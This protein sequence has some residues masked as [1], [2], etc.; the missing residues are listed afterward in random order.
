LRE[1]IEGELIPALIEEGR[2]LAEGD[3]RGL[4]YA[5]LAEEIQRRAARAQHWTETYWEHFIPYAHGARLFGQVYNDAVRPQDPFEFIAL[6]QTGDMESVRRNAL[7][8]RIADVIR[9]DPAIAEA[10]ESGAGLP[11]HV[12]QMISELAHLVTPGESRAGADTAR[13]ARLALQASRVQGETTGPD[14]LAR[15]ALERRFLESVSEGQRA[16]ALELLDLARSSYRLRDDDNVYLGR[17]EAQVAAATEE[18]RRRLAGRVAYD[19]ETLAPADVVFALRDTAFVPIGNAAQAPAP[20]ATVR[21]RQLTGQPAGPGV[22]T[23]PARVIHDGEDLFRVEAGDVLVCDAIDPNMTFVV[24]VCSAVVERR[25]GMLIHGA[26]IAREYG[27]PCVTGVPDATEFI[28]TGDA[29]TVDGFLGIVVVT[30][31]DRRSL[32]Q[33]EPSPSEAAT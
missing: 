2:E 10:I 24:P 3:L 18:G 14:A 4:D 15:E 17:L 25:G 27:L 23:G 7:L 5:S 22:A 29:L 28:Q 20:Q 19:V 13:I 1:R 9:Q 12:Q 8:K 31:P 30:R 33:P 16:W 26:I 32:E 21:P 11:E 6:L